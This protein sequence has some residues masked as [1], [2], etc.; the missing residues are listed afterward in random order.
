MC[1]NYPSIKYKIKCS[2]KVSFVEQVVFYYFRNKK[3]EVKLQLRGWKL[4]SLDTI[5]VTLVD[6]YL[7]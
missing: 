2:I 3:A 6:F 1:A 5:N 7:F 4:V